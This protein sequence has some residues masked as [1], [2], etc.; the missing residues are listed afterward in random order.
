MPIITVQM[1][2][3]RTAAQTSEFIKQVAEVAMRTLDVPERAITIAMTEVSP[4]AWGVGS[5]TMAEI[6]AAAPGSPKP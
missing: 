2:S 4:D 6:R 3:G 5:K 1:L